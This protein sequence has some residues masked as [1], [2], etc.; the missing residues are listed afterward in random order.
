MDNPAIHP[1]ERREAQYLTVGSGGTH[2]LHIL[3]SKTP[4]QTGPFALFLSARAFRHEGLQTHQS[5]CAGTSCR[6]NPFLCL[7]VYRKLFL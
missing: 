5:L 2:L 1:R 7:F 4:P 6:S 3:P